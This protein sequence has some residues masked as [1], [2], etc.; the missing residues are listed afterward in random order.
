[1]RYLVTKEIKSETQVVWKLYF[2][3][4]MFLVIWIAVNL[5]IKE[6]VHVYLQVPFGIFA[7]VTGVL[8]VLPSNLNPKRRQYQ[9]IALYLIRKKGTLYYL[10]KEKEHEQKDRNTRYQ[11]NSS[12]IKIR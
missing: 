7:I 4:F 11:R 2:R 5:Y 8:L 6:K 10:P 3:D 12:K 1:M 9:S